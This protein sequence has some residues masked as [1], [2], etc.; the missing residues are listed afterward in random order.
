MGTIIV[1]TDF[2]DSA[3]NALNYAC[4]FANENKM[5]VLLVHIYTLPASYAAEGVSLAAI[6]DSLNSER[7]MLHEELE[8]VKERYSP[9]QIDAQVIVG[10]FSESLEDL[11]S[12]TDPEMI[13]MGAEEEYSELWNWGVDWLNALITISCPVMVVPRHI[14]YRRIKNIAFACDYKNECTPKQLTTIKKFAG[15]SHAGFYVV[16]VS[17]E[18]KRPMENNLAA[19]Q[20]AFN[21]MNPQFHTVENK[22]I[23][24][25]LAEFIDEYQIDLLLVIPRRHGLW[26]SLFNKSYTKQL[27]LLNNLPVI[28]IH[29]D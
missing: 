8:R 1:T 21:D 5:A 19:F 23:I 25:G 18:N 2:S 20:K 11:S 10:E 15:L 17:Q 22:F 9:V 6:D 7:Q 13:M 27:A 4:E 29:E 12:Q 24:K 3:A 16:H 26:H 14:V 28:A